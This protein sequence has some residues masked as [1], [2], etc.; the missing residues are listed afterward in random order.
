MV[1]R[2]QRAGKE[3]RPH[4]KSHQSK[5]I[6]RWLREAGVGGITVSSVGM[7]EYFASDFW[8][9][10]TI[11]F[12]CNLREIDRINA[13]AEQVQLTLLVDRLDVAEALNQRL[14]APVRV[15]IE[16]DCGY[17]RTGIPWS[18]STRIE[19]LAKFIRKS[20]AMDFAGYY[21]H[22]GHTYAARDSEQIRAIAEEAIGNFE[23]AIAGDKRPGDV[24][25]G[26][27]PSC[28]TLDNFGKKI[29][30]LSPGNFVFYDLSQKAIGSCS[31]EDIGLVMVCPVVTKTD[32]ASIIYGGGAHFC[33]D[34][35]E[36][37]S[38][39]LQ[40]ELGKSDWTAVETGVL[41][42]ISQEHG[43]LNHSEAAIGEVV[44][45]LPVHSCMTGEMMGKYLTSEGLYLDH[46][47]KSR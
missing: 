19:E 7:A 45:I 15:L 43:T 39:G 11:A 20:R 6:G 35:L 36:D 25:F 34:K 37:G 14:M 8:Q 3:L 21:T 46:Y 12:P 31:L 10:I 47:L 27:T 40:V 33:K 23:S 42:S 28:S 22:A 9:D 38:Y 30:V 1:R 5:E 26:D 4:M 18:D 13:L 41:Q 44:A 2:A 29:T 17:G 16:I 24:I 32:T